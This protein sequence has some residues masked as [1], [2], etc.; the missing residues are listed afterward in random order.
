MIDYI[1]LDVSMK[2]TAVPI[3]REKRTDL[4]READSNTVARAYAQAVAKCRA[5]GST[6]PARIALGVTSA[7]IS[8]A[9]AASTRDPPNVT[10]RGRAKWS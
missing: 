1:G 3:R 2:E 7:S 9:T 5:R 10:R 8:L 4:A 6:I